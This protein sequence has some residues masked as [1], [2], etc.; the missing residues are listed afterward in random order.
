MK[1]KLIAAS[2][3]LLVSGASF[4][5][6]KDLGVLDAKGADFGA[7]FARIFSFGSPLGNFTDHYTFSLSG[8]STASG[9]TLVAMELGSL[10]LELKSVSLSGAGSTT[11]AT[12]TDDTPQGFS[13]SKLGAGTYVLDV[14]G[15]LK[16]LGGPAGYAEYSGSIRSMASA[17]PEPAALAMTLAGLIVVGLMSRRR[18][19]S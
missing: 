17:A 2:M 8:A 6:T 1:L 14:A 10:D 15:V 3:A 18:R 11:Y 5:L 4:A 16:S 12:T 19:K 9:G 7:K 13:F